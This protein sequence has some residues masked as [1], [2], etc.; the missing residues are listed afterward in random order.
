MKKFWTLLALV[1]IPYLGMAQ[2][3]KGN[4]QGTVKDVNG[5]PLIGVNVV[6]QGTT[7]GTITD[8]DGN[9]TINSVDAGER[10]II[11]TYIGFTSL[12]KNM[13]V[14]ANQTI[15][16]ELILQE[17]EVLLKEVVVSAQKREEKIQ[18]VPV[19]I[20]VL[21]AEKL[22]KLGNLELADLASFVPGLNI[23]VQSTNR[24]A[25]VIRGL[26]SIGNDPGEQP[27]VSVFFND[28]PVSRASGAALEPYDMDRIEALKGPQGTLFGRGAQIGAVHFIPKKPTRELES[29]IRL[30]YGNFNYTNLTGFV[31]TPLSDKVFLRIAGTYDA[32]DGFVDNTFGGD[33]NGKG[34]GAARLSLRF[35]PS[36]KSTLDFMFD[37]QK[38]DSPGVAFITKNLPNTNGEIGI[39]ND[40]ASL[41]QGENLGASKENITMSL[42]YKLFLNDKTTLTSIS[43]LRY[44]EAFERFDGDG[45]AARV[46]D[47]SEDVEADQFY[48]EI[49]FNYNPN[50]KLKTIFGAS[51]FS[52]DVAQERLFRFNEQHAAWL[53]LGVNNLVDANGNPNS[54]PVLP[55]SLGGLELPEEH[56][57]SQ[58]QEGVNSAL[59]IFADGTYDISD[60]FSLTAGLRFVN[61]FL[62]LQERGRFVE[63]SSPSVLGNFT[64]RAPNFFLTIN[65][66]PEVEESFTALTGRFI[67]KYK[68]SEE[69][70]IFFGYA[71]GRRPNV[72]EFRA[73]GTTDIL[74]SENVNSFDL[75]YKALINRR[76]NIGLALFYQD[77]SNFRTNAFN[78]ALT[79][80]E[81]EVF[82]TD[83]GKASAFGIE[84]DFSAALSK[85]FNLFGNYNYIRARFSDSNAD[86]VAQQFSGNRFR[87][88]P[89]HTFGLG[90]DA[91]FPLS[92]NTTF[93]A[94]PNYSFK[95][96]HFFDDGNPVDENNPSDISLPQNQFQEAF[97]LMNI[98]VGLDLKKSGLTFTIFANNLFDKEYIID[99]G[100]TGAVF[101]LPTYVQGLPLTYGGRMTWNIT[102]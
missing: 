21:G 93:F 50:E 10:T 31:N 45:T 66:F 34:T 3:G 24:P 25:Y 51:Y 47:N 56:I 76:V 74:S 102:K 95:S 53:L 96:K 85:N 29:Q 55:E 75:G 44:H 1:L 57:E 42:H 27:R 69:S 20:S 2:T 83:V 67:A 4:I 54:L 78:D 98:N 8:F 89:D 82:V 18:D 73:D 41:E 97:G 80:G 65:D 70:N 28:I 99:A 92:N 71:R 90:I 32:R 61:D 7:I 46:L 60:K 63:T 26:S 12:S 52:E 35:L 15:T 19:A 30:G 16:V 36:S 5:E 62:K 72:I 49:R 64:R 81:A 9:Y 68:F 14:I 94:R 101:G 22:E 77:Y 88:T 79:E 48:Q 6:I 11:A 37:Y 100:N 39:F 17:S 58:T 13:T 59:E 43:S 38:D 84:L 87:L 33:L 40:E 23:Q 91:N 86:G